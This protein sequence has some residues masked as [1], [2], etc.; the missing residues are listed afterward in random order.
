VT[1]DLPAR[2]FLRRHCLGLD[3]QFVLAV[4]AVASVIAGPEAIRRGMTIFLTP[5]NP[6]IT[7]AN[8]VGYPGRR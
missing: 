5:S 8:H 6:A 7:F 2:S 3:A 4:F 1:Y